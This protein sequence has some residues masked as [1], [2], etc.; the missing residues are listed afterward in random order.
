MRYNSMSN[1]RSSSLLIHYL[2]PA[3][4]ETDRGIWLHRNFD[5]VLVDFGSSCRQ[6]D[7]FILLTLLSVCFFGKSRFVR[8]IL[9]KMIQMYINLALTQVALSLTLI[10]DLSDKLLIGLRVINRK[11]GMRDPDGV[12]AAPKSTHS[13]IDY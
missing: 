12:A 10:L 8:I 11:R 6:C 9:E 2:L 1:F 7:V 13:P 3:L 4:I 5:R